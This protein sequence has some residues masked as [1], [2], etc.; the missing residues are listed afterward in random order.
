MLSQGF[1]I[2]VRELIG[3]RNVEQCLVEG[4]AD[5]SLDTY[6]EPLADHQIAGL[7]NEGTL[8]DMT[9]VVRFRH[10]PLSQMP[11]GVA[12]STR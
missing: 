5:P 3:Q 10:E 7:V 1:T 8:R 9:S 2:C 4:I 12:E 6:N 11:V